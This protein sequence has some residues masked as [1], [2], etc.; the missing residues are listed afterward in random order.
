MVNFFLAGGFP[1]WFTLLFS[2]LALV[3]AGTFV[4]RGQPRSIAV[5]R[6]LTAAT[7]FV[8]LGGATAD[9]SA[10]MW[11]AARGGHP[12]LPLFVMQG[13]GEAVTP[14]TLGFSLISIAWLLVAVRLRR[15][16]EPNV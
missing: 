14:V 1:M 4:R 6:A 16:D 11:K 9:F 13:L 5:L 15:S 2:V 7:V 12:D 10:V 3:T 8:S